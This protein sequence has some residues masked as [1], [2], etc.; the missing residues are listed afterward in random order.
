LI[1]RGKKKGKPGGRA[2]RESNKNVIRRRN[3]GLRSNSKP[4]L[5][6]DIT[7]KAI[8]TKACFITRKRS[9]SDGAVGLAL[10]A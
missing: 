8:S 3:H 2:A 9:R 10:E 4:E 6:I 7:S 5:P 1:Y